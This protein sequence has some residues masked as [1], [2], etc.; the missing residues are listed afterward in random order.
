[1]RKLVKNMDWLIDFS[2]AK[3]RIGLFEFVGT[4]ASGVA[5]QTTVGNSLTSLFIMR[6]FCRALGLGSLDIKVAGDNVAI[7]CSES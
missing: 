6:A 2:H 7:G 4:T 1:V 5:L 3:Q